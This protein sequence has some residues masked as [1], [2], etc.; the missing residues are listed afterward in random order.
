[1]QR[2]PLPVRPVQGTPLVDGQKAGD[3]VADD[4]DNHDDDEK[5]KAV[6]R[7]QDGRLLSRA[8][9]EFFAAK[10]A[11][12]AEAS[13]AALSGQSDAPKGQLKPRAQARVQQLQ[14]VDMRESLSSASS[15][16]SASSIVSAASAASAASGSKRRQNKASEPQLPTQ[17]PEQFHSNLLHLS[18]DPVGLLLGAASASQLREQSNLRVDRRIFQALTQSA[19]R[20]YDEIEKH[21]AGQAHQALPAP[22]Q[23]KISDSTTKHG[24]RPAQ[25][26]PSGAAPKRPAVHPEFESWQDYC[27]EQLSRRSSHAATL[28][29]L[30]GKPDCHPFVFTLAPALKVTVAHDMDGARLNLAQGKGSRQPGSPGHHRARSD[31]EIAIDDAEAAMAQPLATIALA[32][33]KRLLSKLLE[34][35]A[36][37]ESVNFVNAFKLHDSVDLLPVFQALLA[38]GDVQ[39]LH[40]LIQNHAP[41]RFN[42][43][44][45]VEN[46]SIRFVVHRIGSGAILQNDAKICGRV[47]AKFPDVD[48]RWFPG[49]FVARRLAAMPWL[50]G[51]MVKT[52]ELEMLAPWGSDV[53]DCVVDLVESELE[54]PLPTPDRP[55]PKEIEAAFA[56][57]ST[58]KASILTSIMSLL[59]NK[60]ALEPIIHK[61]YDRFPDVIATRK[62][63]FKTPEAFLAVS[64][65]KSQQPPKSSSGG[66][67]SRPATLPQLPFYKSQTRVVFVDSQARLSEMDE[68]IPRIERIGIDA[69]WHSEQLNPIAIFQIACALDSGER[70]VFI[71]DVI[72]LARQDMA[73]VLGR[74]FGNPHIVTLGEVFFRA[75]AAAL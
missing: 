14:E 40:I 39:N 54:I 23:T 49:M 74:L 64:G 22:E 70:C 48:P 12:D 55:R 33:A 61:I 18:K 13:A 20:V 35:N 31:R 36:L 3:D 37:V 9:E 51:E 65:A 46:A 43:F 16:S 24:Q 26:P 59:K 66:R 73:P 5:L 47:V 7:Q 58:L 53:F 19:S 71:L 10:P 21:S 68:L 60:T 41:S 72:N 27:A 57:E 25:Q 30:M 42:L 4:D 28:A 6:L 75:A 2:L 62:S 38:H 63:F 44:S 50:V 52:I 17:L 34:N 1:M 45:Y 67:R 56:S 29:R 8:L 32:D 69:E 11:S 15:A